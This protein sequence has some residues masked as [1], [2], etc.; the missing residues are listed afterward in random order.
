MGAAKQN[1]MNSSESNQVSLEVVRASGKI[2]KIDVP[3]SDLLMEL[4]SLID[5]YIEA[6]P[7]KYDPSHLVIA[8]EEGLLR[9]LPWNKLASDLTRQTIVGDAVVVKVEDFS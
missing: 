7:M 1:K 5:G 6:V 4:Q 3:K 9:H 8:N 2:E